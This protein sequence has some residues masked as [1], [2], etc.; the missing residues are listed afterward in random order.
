MPKGKQTMVGDL[1]EKCL[2]NSVLRGKFARD[3]VNL[4]MLKTL[5]CV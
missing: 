4:V 2:Q 5:G 3:F 1:E